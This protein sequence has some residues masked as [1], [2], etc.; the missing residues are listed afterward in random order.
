MRR[1]DEVL[2]IGC[3]TGYSTFAFARKAKHVTAVDWRRE[4]LE[5]AEK[6]ARRRR[7]ANVTFLE[8][9]ADDLALPSSS[10]DLV[11]SA[12]AVHHFPDPA[13]AFHEMARVC[14]PG[15][16]VAIE[17]VLAPEQD[18]RA[19]YQNRLE[20]LRDRGHQKFLKLSELVAMLGLA[21]LAVE[22]VEVNDSI[23]EFNEWV[24]VT[25]PPIRRTEHIRRLLQG[26]VE[27]DL[28]GLAVEREDDTFLFV[29]RVAWVRCRRPD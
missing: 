13:A 11:V 28:S 9:G 1:D 12:A 16:G 3:G 8:T 7:R 15:G 26:S 23:R 29:Q 24:G 25:R 21:G 17:D 22:R 5:A 4:L 18:I 14:R 10:F 6:G 20:R 19:R 27:Q 2:D